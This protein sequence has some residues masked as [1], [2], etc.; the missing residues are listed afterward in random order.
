MVRPVRETISIFIGINFLSIFKLIVKLELNGFGYTLFISN[1]LID[2]GLDRLSNSFG[3]PGVGVR[4]S[5]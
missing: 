1:E 3:N 2:I 5:H 4:Y